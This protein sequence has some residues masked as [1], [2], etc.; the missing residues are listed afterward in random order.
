MALCSHAAFSEVT[1][2]TN[3]YLSLTDRTR[4]RSILESGFKLD[5]VSSVYYAVS[6]YKLLGEAISKAD[7]IVFFSS[8]FYITFLRNL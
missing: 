2:S 1:Q 7:V 4:L 5:D 3:S 6:G 8:N